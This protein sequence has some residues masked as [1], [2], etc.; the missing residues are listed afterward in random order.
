MADISITCAGCGQSITISEYARP[1]AL[2]CRKCG[3]P[4]PLPRQADA[5]PQESRIRVGPASLSQPFEAPPPAEDP[6]VIDPAEKLNRRTPRRQRKLKQKTRRVRQSRV[7][8]A[9]KGWLLF[10]ILAALLA[11]LRFKKV[12]P[13]NLYEYYRLWGMLMLGFFQVVLIVDAFTEDFFQGIMC[14]LI[15]PY[16]VY[17]LFVVSDAF[18][19]RAVVS[20]LLVAFGWDTAL[21]LHRTAVDVYWSVTNWIQQTDISTQLPP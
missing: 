18:Y 17:Y 21:V 15:P 20:A 5:E 9:I 13:D 4:L 12:L 3:Q 16:T 6:F 1:E 2:T 11:F 10:L 14:L 8:A 7:S 19:L